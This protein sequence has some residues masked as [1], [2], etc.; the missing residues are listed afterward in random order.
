MDFSLSLSAFTDSVILT[1]CH[2]VPCHAMSLQAHTPPILGFK[3]DFY[4]RLRSEHKEHVEE[5]GREEGKGGAVSKAGREGARAGAGVGGRDGRQRDE[6]GERGGG[7]RK[8]NS[9]SRR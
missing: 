4:H 7:E 1:P 3:F 5:R 8:C 6:G 9:F 2:V